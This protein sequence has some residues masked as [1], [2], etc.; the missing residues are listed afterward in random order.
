MRT[1]YS[2]NMSE[3]A[4][5]IKDRPLAINGDGKFDSPG[6][7]ALYGTYTLMDARSSLIISSQLVKVNIVIICVP[8]QYSNVAMVVI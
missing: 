8:K 5:L 4:G 6:H 7:C 1:V 3:V 2:Q